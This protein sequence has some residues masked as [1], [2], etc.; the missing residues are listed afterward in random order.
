MKA[1]ILAGGLGSRLRPFS[2]VIPK[3]LLPLGERAV[4]EVQI[5][6]LRE[7]GCTD[8][9]LAT[10]YMSDFI[11]AFLGNGE[12]YGVR[13]HFSREEKPLG[14]C[15]PLALLKNELTEPFVMLNGDVL[16][17]LDFRALS[18]FGNHHDSLLTVG[19]KIITTP[20]RFGKLTIDSSDFIVGIEEKPEFNVEIVAGIYF[21]K[22]GIFQ[23]IPDGEYFG[24]DSL[25]KA[26]LEQHSPIARYLIT[27]Y[28]LDIGQ[29]EDYSTARKEYE[30]HFASAE[31]A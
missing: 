11:E 26:M 24:M 1:V 16:T 29:V 13:L 10:N 4:T 8:I 19:T 5:Q 20:F 21:I 18:E 25:I 6:Q 31:P 15:G 7:A 2:E 30:E 23:F 17:K 3:P 9:Y 27:D 28:W 14:T 22:P 12:K